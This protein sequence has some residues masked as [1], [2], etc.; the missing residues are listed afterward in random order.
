MKPLVS[1]IVPVHNQEKYLG[2]CLRSL[3][4]QDMT[5]EK[6][7]IIVIDDGSTDRSG[8]ALELFEDELTIISL[9]VN[10]G[11][12]AALNAGLRQAKG[13][14]V[15]RV[16]AD[17][18][19]NSR[20]LSV[21]HIFLESNPEIDAIACDY[22]LVDND[23]VVLGRGNADEQPIACGIMFRLEQLHGLGLYDEAFLSHEDLELRQRFLLEY[24]IDRVPLPFYRY[25]RHDSNMTNDGKRLSQYLK[26]LEDKNALEGG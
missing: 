2:R 6:Y 24:S 25:R 23:E 21:L 16:D 3:L 17:D 26:M 5:R 1:V 20:F 10:Q 8:Y 9:P 18:Y 11:L 13:E 7:E 22:L 4:S 14:L 12:P 15:V 19:V